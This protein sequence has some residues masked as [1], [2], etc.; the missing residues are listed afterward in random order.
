MLFTLTMFSFQAI[1][2]IPALAMI[3]AD[4]ASPA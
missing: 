3:I 1:M 2:I 4:C